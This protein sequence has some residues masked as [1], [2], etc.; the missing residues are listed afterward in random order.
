M[1]ACFIAQ[2]RG[3][4]AIDAAAAT[5]FKVHFAC[6]PKPVTRISMFTYSQQY[7]TFIFLKVM[8][9]TS[10]INDCDCDEYDKVMNM[11]K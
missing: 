10:N 5:C 1:C 6:L 11:V 4:G 9:M 3:L 7:V 8:N 2:I